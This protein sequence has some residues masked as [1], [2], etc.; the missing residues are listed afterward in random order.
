MERHSGFMEF[1]GDGATLV[2]TIPHGCSFKPYFVSTSE[3]TLDA[4][5]LAVDPSSGSIVSAKAYITN[6][7]ATDIIITHQIAPPVGT[8]NLGYWWQA[9]CQ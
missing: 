3:S 4:L 5:G 9:E 1:D 7:N 8:N 2:F 6:A